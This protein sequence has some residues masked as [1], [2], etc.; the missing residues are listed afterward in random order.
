MRN[1]GFDGP[2]TFAC[3]GIN[4]KN[5]EFHAA[6]GLVNLKYIDEIL[7]KRKELY[8]YYV[9]KLE[10]LEKQLQVIQKN[11]EYNHCYFPLILPSEEL[12]KKSRRI[13]ECKP[14]IFQEIFLSIATYLTFR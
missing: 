8:L 2:E 11:T 4:G 10:N 12:I 6:M 13:P 1:F 14:Y 7:E 9:E 5:S 3:V